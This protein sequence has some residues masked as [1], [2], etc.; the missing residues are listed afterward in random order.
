MDIYSG[1]IQACGS[2]TLAMWG[3]SAEPAAIQESSVLGEHAAR[4]SIHL[5][6]YSKSPA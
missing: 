1:E 4:G 6:Y 3:P 5:S 2:N